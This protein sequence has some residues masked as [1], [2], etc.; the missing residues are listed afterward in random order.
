MHRVV[1]GGTTLT[2]LARSN[3]Q[4]TF[5]AAGGETRSEVV[6]ISLDRQLETTNRPDRFVVSTILASDGYAVT[7]RYQDGDL[8]G[9]HPLGRTVLTPSGFTSTHSYTGGNARAI[10]CCWNP[11]W[12]KDVLGNDIKWASEVLRSTLDVTDRDIRN[13]LHRIYFETV[14]PGFCTDVVIDGLGRLLLAQI[15]RYLWGERRAELER[16]VTVQPSVIRRAK[17]YIEASLHLGLT[18]SM[19]AEAAGI[20]RG[21]LMRQ[22]RIA[23]GFTLHS[24]IEDIRTARAKQLLAAE[25]LSIKTISFQLGFSNP[26]AFSV[27]FTQKVGITPRDFRRHFRATVDF[28]GRM[29]PSRPTEH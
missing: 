6:E 17:N 4:V 20:S 12:V 22:F 21:H 13:I 19:I 25:A 9:F 27:A 24:Y 23:T 16:K 10:C 8:E 5:R 7:R 11:N 14:N 29:E 18:T 15:A 3:R 1:S 2:E 28:P 26:S